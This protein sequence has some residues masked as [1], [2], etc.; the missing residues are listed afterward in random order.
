MMRALRSTLLGCLVTISLAA[1]CT[2]AAHQGERPAL[3]T[4][5]DVLWSADH[6]TGDLSQWKEGQGSAVYNTGTAYVRVVRA[7]AP[8]SAR[9][10]EHVLELSIDTSAED[11]TGARIFRWRD[12]P[13]RGYYGAWLYFPHPTEPDEWW[14]V[15][16]FKSPDER[17]VSQPTWVVNVGIDAAGRMRFYL[18]DALE[19]IS[20]GRSAAL[21]DLEVPVGEWVH[22][23]LF[24]HRSQERS[25]RVSMWQD[26]TL[27]FDL[28]DQRTAITDRVHWSINNYST[29]LRP[30]AVTLYADDASIRVAERGVPDGE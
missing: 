27:V 7:E 25:G 24:L 16:Q 9:T 30:S 28:V 2:S 11:V 8:L 17:G 19:E 6:E 26:G 1:A 12:N 14:N 13:E 5:G 20:Y 10:G 15:M 4:P 3:P 22:V 23:E 21:A 29:R 18:W